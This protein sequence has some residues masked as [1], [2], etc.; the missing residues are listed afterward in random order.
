[1]LRGRP[2]KGLLEQAI[3]AGVLLAPGE[4]CGE[5]YGAWARLCFT[6]VPM[7]RLVEGLKRLTQAIKAF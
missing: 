4:G 1:V 3:D 7:P 5:A 6:A 2:L